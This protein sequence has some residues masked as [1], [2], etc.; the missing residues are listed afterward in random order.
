[1]QPVVGSLNEVVV[2]GYGTQKRANVTSAISSIDG[3]KLNEVPAANVSQALQG[4][5][6]GVTVVNNGSPGSQ[7]IVR[8]RGI[9]SISFS[10]DP[11]YVV[12]GV[13][14]GDI[15]SFDMRDIEA[16]DVLKDASAS[17]IYGSRAT[18]GVIVI[19]TKRGKRTGRLHVSLNS[20]YGVQKVTQRLDL[21]DREGF[22][23]YALAYRGSQVPR[24]LPPEVDKPIYAGATQ[25]YGQTN[26]NWQ[27]AYF[28]DGPMTQT[29]ID[30][31]GGNEVSR[32][33]FSAGY[34]NQQGTGPNVAFTRYNFKLSSDHILSKVFTF[35][36]TIIASNSIQNGD[37][38]SGVQEVTW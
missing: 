28:R 31:S 13:P 14:T 23:K 4:R 8:I 32:F 25:T 3:K 35:G 2:I 10:S 9:S 20:F 16:V 27:D 5:M 17:A 36:E 24:L 30:L 19:T 29:N 34:T 11:L 12:D 37:A 15:S 7:P 21:L 26:T 6:A 22:K 18:N 1:M 38:N 33:S